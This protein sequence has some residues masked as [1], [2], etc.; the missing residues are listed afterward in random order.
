MKRI[1]AKL[2]MSVSCP[3]CDKEFLVKEIIDEE[4]KVEASVDNTKKWLKK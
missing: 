3:S 2:E 4:G 1:R